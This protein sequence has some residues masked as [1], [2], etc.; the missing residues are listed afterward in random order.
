[1]L[2]TDGLTDVVPDDVIARRL[3]E[4]SDLKAVCQTLVQDALDRGGPDNITVVTARFSEA[5]DD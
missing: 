3:C 4:R 5:R 2:A 1:M